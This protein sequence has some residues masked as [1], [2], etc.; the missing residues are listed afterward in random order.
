MNTNKIAAP[1]KPLL[2]SR[3]YLVSLIL[4]LIA[5]QVLAVTI[6]FADTMMVSQSGEAA[7][8]AVSLV[9]S[10]SQLF[11]QLF[12]AFATGGAVIS[13]QYL[14]EKNRIHASLAA[15]QLIYVALFSAVI[16]IS[17]S[18][19]F[20]L[21][22]LRT[23]F[24]DIDDSVMRPAVHYLLYV[25]LSFPGLAIFNSCA[26][27]FRS[28]GNSKATMK[29]S[30]VMNI[31]NIA[32]NAWLIFGMGLGVMGAGISTFVAR[33]IA[34]VIM[35]VMIHNKRHPIHI[36]NIFSFEWRP[37]LIKK[38]LRIAVP[39]G[40]ENSMFHIGKLSVQSLVASFGT[41]ALAANAIT[42]SLAGFSN[43]P[44]NAIGL[45]SITI[46]GQCVGAG[47]YDQVTYYSKRFI[48]LVYA[49]IFTLC[50][51]MMFLAHP[52]IQLFNLSTAAS[53][54]AE[55]V[56]MINLLV[57]LV[58][59]PPAFT[60]ANFLRATG[61]ARYTMTVSMFSMWVFRVGLSYLFASFGWG[62][63]GVWIAMY[64]D[65]IVRGTAFSRRMIRGGW[66]N[67][68]VV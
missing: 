50:I 8:S 37:I 35:L 20:R 29:V 4:P 60:V 19:P 45:A 28:M 55:Q 7:V 5:E 52:L 56:L 17:I 22:L 47:E 26:A 51:P 41:V 9:D 31:I 40:I 23:I 32:G 53:A 65:W 67:K 61:D 11:I 48:C 49:A 44:G 68:K 59:W 33:S 1:Q 6:G 10:F 64:I 39:S 2:F 46:I 58:F 16:L 42:N 36:D 27:L 62:L 21:F 38:I 43:I 25:L 34:A 57:S 24:G 54:L 18:L 66:K 14:G 63:Q 3:H 12:A 15:K 13:S 30:L